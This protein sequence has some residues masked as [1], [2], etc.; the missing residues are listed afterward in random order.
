MKRVDNDYITC[1]ETLHLGQQLSL[2]IS[3]L[4]LSASHTEATEEQTITPDKAHV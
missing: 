4:K 3:H 1:E 2:F